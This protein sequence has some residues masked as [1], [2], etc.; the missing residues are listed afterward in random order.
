KDLRL[1][2]NVGLHQASQDGDVVTFYASEP[3]LLARPDI[4]PTRVRFVLS[5]LESLSG[6]CM[7]AGSSLA[8]DHGEAV[9]TV[10]RAAQ[11][12]KADAVYW[13]DEYEPS[14]RARDDAVERVLRGAGVRV[15]RFHDR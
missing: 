5:S 10:L 1:I 12:C 11:A 13:N 7:R 15:R 8:L 9:D 14:L 2:D 3:S 6:A 4:A